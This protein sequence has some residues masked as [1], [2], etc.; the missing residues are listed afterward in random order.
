MQNVSTTIDNNTTT[1]NK[2]SFYERIG[3]SFGLILD[4]GILRNI[5]SSSYPHKERGVEECR[6]PKLHSI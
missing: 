6:L 3:S 5:P 2:S 4:S 1:F